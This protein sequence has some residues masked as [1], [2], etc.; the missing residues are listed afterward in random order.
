MLDLW[1]ALQAEEGWQRGLLED[2][3]HL[4]QVSKVSCCRRSAWLGFELF[5][6]WGKLVYK[7]AP[8]S[9]SGRWSPHH[10]SETEVWPPWAP[11]SPTC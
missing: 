2:G 8:A 7:C 11:S 6:L 9:A 3:L 5:N 4:T 10:D 1:S